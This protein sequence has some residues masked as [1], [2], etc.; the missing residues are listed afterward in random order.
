MWWTLGYAMV[1]AATLVLAGAAK[2]G[3]DGWRVWA[4]RLLAALALLTG[5][6][7]MLACELAQ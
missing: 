5:G 2:A 1:V 7:G 6:I 4:S 3:N